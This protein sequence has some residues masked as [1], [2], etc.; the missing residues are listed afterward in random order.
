LAAGVS[1]GGVIIGSARVREFAHAARSRD[2]GLIV[3]DR[4][5]G[6][7]AILGPRCRVRVAQRMVEDDDAA[8]TGQPLE[9]QKPPADGS[10][11]KPWWD[12]YWTDAQRK[13]DREL[14][15]N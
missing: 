10:E 3:V 2:E 7:V 8:R 9:L 5:H 15:G 4:H 6:L 11:D 13:N 1:V 14:F 12:K